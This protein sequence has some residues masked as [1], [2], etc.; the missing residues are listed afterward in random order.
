MH[1]TKIYKSLQRVD[2]LCK[3]SQRPGD[4]C[5]AMQ[6]HPRSW[7]WLQGSPLPG[8][9]C[10]RD[11]IFSC[12]CIRDCKDARSLARQSQIGTWLTIASHIDEVIQGAISLHGLV[13]RTGECLA[14][15]CKDT[16]DFGGEVMAPCKTIPNENAAC[17]GIPFPQGN[18]RRRPPQWMGSAA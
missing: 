18:P 4:P 1:I 12:I 3:G 17:S 16:R 6:D 13:C 15:V 2:S 11:P 14:S 10:K 5:L 8:N 7:G 9:L